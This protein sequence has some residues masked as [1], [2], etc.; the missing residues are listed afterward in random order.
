MQEK[1]EEM[2]KEAEDIETHKMNVLT[3]NLHLEDGGGQ[4]A[5][6]PNRLVSN[7]SWT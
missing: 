6:G 1:Y 7:R 2:K 5:L 4:S 3:A